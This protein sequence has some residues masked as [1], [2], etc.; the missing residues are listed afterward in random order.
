MRV[1]RYTDKIMTRPAQMNL[2][3]M[4]ASMPCR[5]DN[6][7]LPALTAAV[8]ASGWVEAHRSMDQEEVCLH[9]DSSFVVHL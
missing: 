2:S 3:L 9:I 5:S 6:S 1:N 4:K 8:R 7:R